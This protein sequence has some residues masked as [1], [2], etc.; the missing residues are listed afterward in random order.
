MLNP[1]LHNYVRSILHFSC[2]ISFS[3]ASTGAAAAAIANYLDA[4]GSGSSALAGGAGIQTFAGSL[5]GS[6]V[7]A[8][9]IA[10][11]LDALGSDSSALAGGAGIQSYTGNFASTSAIQGSAS[12]IKVS[13]C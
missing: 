8:A 13:F 5:S 11:Y 7:A 1:P 4:L 6:T 2:F 3:A 12:A 9:A 10:N